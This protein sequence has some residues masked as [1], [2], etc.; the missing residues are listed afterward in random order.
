MKKRRRMVT[1]VCIIL[2]VLMVLPFL[3][4]ALS[5]GASAKAVTQKEIDDLKAQA[6]ELKKQSA[7]L[8][9]QINS[10][11]FQQSEI[12]SQKTVL[13]ERMSITRE[14]IDNLTAQIALYDTLIAEK[15]KELAAAQAAETKQ[16]EEFK[17]RIRAMEEN[18]TISYLA[19][20]LEADSFE[21]LLDRVDM[22]SEIMEYDRAVAN[23]L[24]KAKN[25]TIAAKNALEETQEE[26]KL[27][28]AELEVKEAELKTQSEEAAQLIADLQNDI[29]AYADLYQQSE[30][31]RDKLQKEINE[32]VAELERIEREKRESAAYIVSTGTYIWPTTN[33]RVVTSQFGT[34]YHPVL[35]YYRTH[36]G[37]DIGADYGTEILAAD[38]GLVA[39]SAYDSSYGNYVVIS[40]GNG[41]TT[42]YAHMSKRMVKEGDTVTQGQTVGLVGATGVVTGPHIHFETRVNG[43]RVDPL[44]Y[45][46][47]YILRD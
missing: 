5:G 9:S 12:I 37:I 30:S 29:N 4:N 15:R 43:S 6:A 47:N 28:K 13:D 31:E 17:H 10:L 22:V 14:E 32:K 41:R 8:Q 23:A 3:L 36:N 42:L 16:F 11:Q 33:T 24:T 18:G 34:R 45:F 20:I 44:Q 25:E 40:H 46:S 2:V 39:V 38:G 21:N 26:Q 27:A 35:H 1:I 7:D 19:V